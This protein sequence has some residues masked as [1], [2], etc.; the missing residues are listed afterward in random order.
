MSDSFDEKIR[1][2][3]TELVKDPPATPPFPGFRPGSTSARSTEEQRGRIHPWVSGPAVAVAIFVA[4]L[5]VGAVGLLL[6]P[7]TLP[8]EVVLEPPPPSSISAPTLNIADIPLEP[9]VPFQAEVRYSKGRT[10][11]DSFFVASVVMSYRS[12]GVFRAEIVSVSPTLEMG[13]VESSG[14]GSFTVS[15]DI[16]AASYLAA[17]DLFLRFPAEELANLDPGELAWAHWASRCRTGQIIEETTILSRPA[18]HIRCTDASG[19]TDVWVDPTTGVVLAVRVN[20]L[21]AAFPVASDLGIGANGFRVEDLEVEAAFGMHTFAVSTPDGSEEYVAER[22][23]R[24][25]VA[26]NSDCDLDCA[27]ADI[28]RLA[29][30]SLVGS[31]APPLAGVL[32][33]GTAF[34]LESLRGERVVLLWWASWCA[35]AIERLH[36]FD[37]KA[38]ERTDIRFIGVN[39]QDSSDLSRLAVDRGGISVPT[40]DATSDSGSF[41]IDWRI[42]DLPA[43]VLIAEDGT[44]M[45]GIAGAW[46]TG[47]LEELFAQAGW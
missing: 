11:V 12:P 25:V 6:R 30:Y 27:E 5:V 47:G 32:L 46:P 40:L 19:D 22:R 13:F 24:R 34:D 10:T 15:D 20:P 41:E 1:V 17:N 3:V 45:I 21:G 8:E 7:S 18:L 36:P 37:Q 33:D 2:F 9:V 43:T 29:D 4:V 28:A 26:G 14:V 35:P 38:Y 39:V 23:V 16:D 42:R 44:V 31:P